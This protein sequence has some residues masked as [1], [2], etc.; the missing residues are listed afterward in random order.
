[1]PK[2]AVRMQSPERLVEGSGPPAGI[3]A[4]MGDEE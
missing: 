2:G 4:V 1:M 3:E